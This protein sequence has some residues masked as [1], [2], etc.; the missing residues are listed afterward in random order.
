MN[1]GRLAGKTQCMGLAET[2]GEWLFIFDNLH[3]HADTLENVTIYVTAQE[4]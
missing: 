4:A 2:C 3:G 1:G